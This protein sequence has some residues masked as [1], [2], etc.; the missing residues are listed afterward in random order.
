ML[1]NQYLVGKL[2]K[3]LWYDISGKANLYFAMFG[4]IFNAIH[5]WA[6]ISRQG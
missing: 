5:V 4:P 2:I 6:K 3:A 1:T